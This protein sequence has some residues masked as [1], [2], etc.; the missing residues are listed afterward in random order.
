MK[1][2]K[3]GLKEFCQTVVFSSF[4][5]HLYMLGEPLMNTYT[6]FHFVRKFP[7]RESLDDVRA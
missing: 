5:S 2:F 7:W 1:I 4:Y 3:K 6:G